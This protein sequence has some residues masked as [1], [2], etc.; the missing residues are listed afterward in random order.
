MCQTHGQDHWIL[1]C[2]TRFDVLDYFQPLISELEQAEVD[3]KELVFGVH[4]K[5]NP[6]MLQNIITFTI[7]FSIHKSRGTSFNNPNS[8]RAKRRS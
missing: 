8:A 5:S 7:Q 2:K 4:E 1:H 3:K 6:E